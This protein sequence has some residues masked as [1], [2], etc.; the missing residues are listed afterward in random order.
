MVGTFGS[1][2]AGLIDAHSRAPFGWAPL[3]VLFI[4]GLVDRIEHN[5]LSGVLPLIQREWGFSDTA[6][7][8]I[9]TAAAL[10]AAVVSLPMRL[11][12]R[13]V[14][15]YAH[16]RDRRLLLGDRHARLGPGHRIRPVL[17]DAGVPG[18]GREHR[19]SGRGQSAGRLLPARQPGQG[20][21]AD[22]RHHLPGRRRH[23][24]RRRAGREL[25]L[26]YR[27]PH[28]G[29][30]RRA[31]GGAR[32]VPARAAPRR[33]RPAGGRG[34]VTAEGLPGGRGGGQAAVPGP[35]PPG[36]GDPDADLR[37]RRAG[38]AQPGPGL[39]LLLAAHAHG[40]DLRR[41]RGHGRL[42]QRPH[43]RRGNPH[44]HPGRLV[45][46][47]EM[48]RHPPGRLYCS[49]VAAASRRAPWSSPS[50]CPWTRSPRSRCWFC[51][52]AR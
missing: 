42:A 35:A 2:R 16:H 18:G 49:P 7:S 5:L 10:A 15:P 25:R 51:S 14:Q 20:V 36:G 21:R 38:P 39:R 23:P 17:P 26:A 24:A 3:V 4:V 37:L 40:A 27:V 30:A 1:P 22:P 52:P 34:R 31:H 19:Q 48:A 44:R 28:H 9:P 11:S 46:G 41:R 6:A 12:G 8:S 29:R 50:R 47:P 43:H 33:A 45:A 32:L 13:P